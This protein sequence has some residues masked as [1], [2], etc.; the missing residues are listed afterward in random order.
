MKK[1]AVSLASVL[2]GTVSGFLLLSNLIPNED[3]IFAGEPAQ[4]VYLSN[5]INGI[6]YEVYIDDVLSR[7]FDDFEEALYYAKSQERAAIFQNSSRTWVWDNYPLFSVVLDGR[8]VEFERFYQA[9]AYAREHENAFVIHRPNQAVAWSNSSNLESA[10]RLDVPVILQNPALP[11]GCEVTSLAML[12]N[13]AGINVDKMTLA[14]QVRKNPIERE[15]INGVIHGGHPN[16]G[17]VGDMFNS[18]PHGL[19]VF[20]APIFELAQ[21]YLPDSA[22]DLTG[23]NF[24]DLLFFLNRGIPVWVITNATFD[25]LRAS[26]FDTWVTPQGEI[27][28]TYWLHAVVIS[29]YD[30]NYIYFSDPLLD[31][32]VGRTHAPREAFIAAWEQMGRQAITYAF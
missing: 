1:L 9:T 7:N 12:L 22:I 24:E 6:Y 11:R 18:G 15:V 5:S 10:V 3:D 27:Q 13:H 2:I 29:G 8:F 30:E 25:A 23:S 19:G 28:I 26:D 20:H 32:R 21:K 14:H 4:S 16:Y 17:F 31:Q